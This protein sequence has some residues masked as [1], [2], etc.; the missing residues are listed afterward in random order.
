MTHNTPS[1]PLEELRLLVERMRALLGEAR[2]RYPEDVPPLA[3]PKLPPLY[4]FHEEATVVITTTVVTHT[5][6][7]FVDEEGDTSDLP[8]EFATATMGHILL[9]Q[10]KTDEARTVFTS[11]LSRDATDAEALRGMSLLGDSPVPVSTS[12][13]MLDHETPATQYGSVSVRALSVDPTSLHAHWEIPDGT[14]PDAAPL[15]LMV[16]SL[17][18]GLHGEV[19]RIEKRFSPIEN[20]GNQFVRDLPAGAHHHVAVGYDTRDTF[21]PVAQAPVVKAPRGAQSPVPATEVSEVVAQSSVHSPT[22]HTVSSTPLI[23]P[24]SDLLARAVSS[25]N[26]SHTRNPAP[27]EVF[28]EAMAS[29]VRQ[30]GNA[31]S[32]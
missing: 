3:A 30:N 8:N 5:T 14:T 18:T 23:L 15:S 21:A 6:T 10:G 31:P 9:A 4:S 25:L 11:V 7:S 20:T 19:E 26:T 1:D 32:S 28:S 29:W 27:V 13:T 2:A 22:A 24:G 17:R 16:L 12:I